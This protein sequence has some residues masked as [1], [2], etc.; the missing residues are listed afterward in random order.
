MSTHHDKAPAAAT[1]PDLSRWTG[2]KAEAFLRQ[3]ALHGSVTRAAR[4]VGMSRKAAYA[5]RARAPQFAQGW[6]I[7]RAGFL[8]M[9]EVERLRKRAVHP[10][11]DRRP[12]GGDD[13]A[14]K[15]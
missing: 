12:V 4:S 14:R 11:L 13:R 8:R 7:A 1:G 5:L 6:G 15:E 2:A 9:R 10:L 3:L